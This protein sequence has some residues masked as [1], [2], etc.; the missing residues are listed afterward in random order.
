MVTVT[1]LLSATTMSRGFVGCIISWN[2]SFP[3]TMVSPTMFMA[4]TQIPWPCAVVG[5]I[6]TCVT[7]SVRSAVPKK[8]I[9]DHHT[10]RWEKKDSHCVMNEWN[11]AT[12]L[13]GEKGQCITTLC[14]YFRQTK[15]Q[16]Q[17][18][19]T[20]TSCQFDGREKQCIASKT[21]FEFPCWLMLTTNQ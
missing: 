21:V 9:Q 1:V 5:G 18:Q 2:V 19:V 12:F 11:V 10:P 15:L 17:Q 16:N 4:S 20:R 8:H 13:W 6:T 7:A 3:S 14:V